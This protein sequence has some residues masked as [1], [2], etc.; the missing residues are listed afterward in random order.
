MPLRGLQAKQTKCVKTTTKR[1]RTHLVAP[2]S[3]ER[4]L[5]ANRLHQRWLAGITCIATRDGRLDLNSSPDLYMQRIA[6]CAT[7]D[8][9]T[10]DCPWQP[11]E[12]F[13]PDSSRTLA[14][15][16]LC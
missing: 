13:S 5:K 2:N 14:S 9:M 15:L 1:N 10:S 6:N 8:R 3:L 7:P 12:W 11:W 16:W 4:N